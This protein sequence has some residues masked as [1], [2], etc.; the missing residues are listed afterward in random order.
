MS[1]L[2][3]ARRYRLED[4]PNAASAGGQLANIL[5]QLETSG[6][7]SNTVL[8]YLGREGFLALRRLGAREVMYEDYLPLAE[9]AQAARRA[10]EAREAEAEERRRQ[11]RDRLDAQR[12]ADQRALI[13]S[14]RYQARM[15]AEAL[16]AKY[17]LDS[18]INHDDYPELMRLLR[19]LDE[20]KRITPEDYIWLTRRGRE[21]YECYLTV[22]LAAR[23]HEVEAL[24]HAAQFKLT[25]DPWSAVNASKHFRKWGRPQQAESLL[26]GI[27]LSSIRDPKLQSALLTT[28]GGAKR[29]SDALGE[30]LDF[31]SQ[32]HALTPRD[33]RPCTLQ[34]AVW[35]QMGDYQAGRMWYDKAVERG[36]REEDVDSELRGIM[37]RLAPQK[38]KALGE[39]LLG[40]D[41]RRYDW[42][43]RYV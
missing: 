31:A 7:L 26:G 41:G 24:F 9:Q 17:D 39:H 3:T 32:A 4:V 22:E 19:L 16:R 13:N 37:R 40:Q 25:G 10:V 38:R 20:G 5:E 29:D 35:Y 11:E 2:D 12:E 34:G 8:N 6:A 23:Y 27:D 18:F 21:N 36:F 30:A 42:A 43:R 33:F 28:R 15:R 1:S 14:P